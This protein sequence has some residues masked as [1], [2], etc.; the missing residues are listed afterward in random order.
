MI[1][2]NDDVNFYSDERVSMATQ[3][4]STDELINRAL[5]AALYSRTRMPYV[6]RATVMSILEVFSSE[7]DA[8]AAITLTIIHI[9]RQNSRNE[10]NDAA[11]NSLVKTLLEIKNKGGGQKGELARKFLGYYRWLFEYLF[12]SRK[13]VDLPPRAI[14]ELTFSDFVEKYAIGRR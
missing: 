6:D 11:A 7:S 5:K 1:L 14:E 12:Y 3:L 2:Y 9:L 8:D 13:R 10:I 4:F